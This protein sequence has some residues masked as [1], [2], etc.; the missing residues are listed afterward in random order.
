[1][2]A[3]VIILPNKGYRG[4]E[5]TIYFVLLTSTRDKKQVGGIL[6]QESEQQIRK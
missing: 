2:K 6:Y 5:A 3:V 1:M 4:N